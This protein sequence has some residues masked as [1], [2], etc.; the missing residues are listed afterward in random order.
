MYKHSG[1]LFIAT[2]PKTKTKKQKQKIGWSHIIIGKKKQ[3]QKHH[4][5][6]D[7]ITF[8]ATFQVT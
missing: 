7:V 5:T 8:K 2:I 6:K 4:T 3:Q 1:F